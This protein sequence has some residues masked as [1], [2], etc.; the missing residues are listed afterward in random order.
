MGESFMNMLNRRSWSVAVA[1]LVASLAALV[2]LHPIPA[3]EPGSEVLTPGLFEGSPSLTLSNGTLELT[4]LPQGA[5]LVLRDDSEK[6]NPLWNPVRMKREQG[7]KA[8]PTSTA[9]HLVCVDG[10]G[11]VSPEES[12]A[13]LPGHGEAHLQTFDVHSSK[14]GSTAEVTLAAKLP[15]V[16]EAFTR[17]LRMVDGENVVYFESQLENLMGFDRPI[18]WGEHATVGSPFVEPGVTV[19]D[20][21][22]SRSRTRPYTEQSNPPAASQQQRRLA[23]DKDFTWPLAPGLD[24]KQVDMRQSPVNPHYID[25]VATLMD[26]SRQLEWVTALNPKLKLVLGYL[27]RREE[28]PWL[29]TWASS[30]PSLKMARGIEFATQPFDLPR[31]EVITAGSMFDTLTYRWL[32]A[33]SKI[34][35]HFLMFYTRVP[36]GFTKVDDVR[37]ENGQ[38]I[39]EDRTSGKKVTLAASL[40]L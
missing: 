40:K 33:K 19:F 8:D 4:V 5:S 10:F 36:D 22:G 18:N 13:G 6:L 14:N 24:G 3:A 16:Q 31:R 20:L 28:Y 12:Q 38:I 7:L 34:T 30:P 27:F 11:R 25:H 26:P 2:M 37:M 17:T 32:P 15:I 39:I 9:G 21:S 23:S 29:Q 35:T 1:A